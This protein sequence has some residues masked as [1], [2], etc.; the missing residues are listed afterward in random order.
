MALLRMDVD[1][2][3]QTAANLQTTGGLMEASTSALTNTI[4][5]MVGTAWIAPGA[6]EFNANF[7][8]WQT[9]VQQMLTILKEMSTALETEVQEWEQVASTF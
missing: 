7:Q 5:S 3:R 1:A 4:N 6:S 2:C 8:Q 9:G